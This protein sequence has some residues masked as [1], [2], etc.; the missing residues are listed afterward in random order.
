[1]VF[2]EFENIDII[3]KIRAGYDPLSDLVRP[4]ITLVFPFESDITTDELNKHIKNALQ[5]C[6]S[7]DLN[8]QGFTASAEPFSNYLFLNVT[9][10]L[11]E[12]CQ[13][14]R[15][16][17]T[18]ILEQYQSDTLKTNYCP[19]LTVGNLNK[20]IDYHAI[21][22]ELE[23]EKSLFSTCVNCVSVEIIG[24]DESS[25]LEMTIPLIL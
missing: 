16:L 25:N 7:F 2:P 18:G 14:S 6:R 20:N 3:D 8:M 15:N 13:L 19:H 11:Q 12:L 1:M 24:E 21:L 23:K 4:H 10:G 9:D 5:D 17:Y 22:N